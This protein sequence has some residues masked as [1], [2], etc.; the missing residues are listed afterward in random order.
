MHVTASGFVAIDTEWARVFFA[1]WYSYG[2]L[3]L[4]NIVTAVFVSQFTGYLFKLYIES[5]K[6][7]V[8]SNNNSNNNY[9]NN[10]RNDND[11][12]NDNIIGKSDNYDD[13]DDCYV[14][15]NDDDKNNNSNRVSQTRRS[16]IIMDIDETLHYDE[17][18]IDAR[19]LT[20]LQ[21]FDLNELRATKKKIMNSTTNNNATAYG[22]S[23][24]NSNNAASRIDGNSSSRS[25]VNAMVREY[26]RNVLLYHN[27]NAIDT[28][29]NARHS[30]RQVDNN[31][32]NN[33]NIINNNNNINNNSRNSKTFIKDDNDVD[34]DTI[35]PYDDTSLSFTSLS[36]R[37]RRNSSVKDTLIEGVNLIS[38]LFVLD[39]QHYLMSPSISKTDHTKTAAL[40]SS[41]SLA[42]TTTTTS[43]AVTAATFSIRGKTISKDKRNINDTVSPQ[44]HHNDTVGPQ[45]HHNDTV[46]PQQ[47][48][49]D[50]FI[51]QGSSSTTPRNSFMSRNSYIDSHQSKYQNN[52]N[53][54]NNITSCNSTNKNDHNK[55][56][57]LSAAASDNAAI[58]FMHID[59]HR[60]SR[61]QR[62][63]RLKH[64]DFE[65][66]FD[67]AAADDDVSNDKIN[68]NQAIRSRNNNSNSNDNNN[69]SN[70]SN[71]NSN[72]NNHSNSIK[73]DYSNSNKYSNN[74]NSNSYKNNN[75]NINFNDN[76][77]RSI[78]PKFE[79]SIFASKENR[80]RWLMIVC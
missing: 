22:S 54:N 76:M 24:S 15:N 3:M 9:N 48:H 26:S 55:S 29:D 69:H 27:E 46:G 30:A 59:E 14:N 65:T 41:S 19:D 66:K 72:K 11:G 52:I 17:D 60:H 77:V 5:F 8:I 50:P 78:L 21:A 13:H 43:P 40:S 4:L 6:S 1:L 44:Q 53:I 61:L 79:F 64:I 33:N 63:S 80:G 25:S 42:V 73:I 12:K 75:N 58:K 56:L 20:T 28:K 67:D 38:K 35:N 62:H 51:R 71:S 74:I 32:N 49:N 7:T 18:I 10:H 31:N 23:N 39:E 68:I 57:S 34:D 16:S 37:Q 2:V 47:H 70:Y 36:S 45:Q